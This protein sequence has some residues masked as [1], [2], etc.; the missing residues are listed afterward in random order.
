M[1][2]FLD[3]IRSLRGPTPLR[4]SS[5]RFPGVFTSSKHGWTRVVIRAVVREAVVSGFQQAAGRSAYHASHPIHVLSALKVLGSSGNA[6][7]AV[8]ISSSPSVS[9]TISDPAP[10]GIGLSTPATNN[11]YINHGI[12]V[13]VA[14]QTSFV[15]V[16]NESS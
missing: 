12:T 2:P 9:E 10:R 5:P 1:A 8:R 6:P 14:H 15:S 7:A 13:S 16:D 11:Q 4:R 3:P